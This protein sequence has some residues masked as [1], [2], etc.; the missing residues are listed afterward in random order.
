M[1]ILLSTNNNL[2]SY[3]PPGHPWAFAL[4]C[5][6]SPKAFAQQKMP[7]AR[8]ITDDVPGA[9]HLHQLAYRH[10]NLKIKLSDCRREPGKVQKTQNTISNF[11]FALGP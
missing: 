9:A 11:I 6:L 1:G 3:Q 4:K 7:G 2:T 8:P 10:E 5:V